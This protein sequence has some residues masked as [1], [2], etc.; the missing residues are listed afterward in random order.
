MSRT[1]NCVKA[2]LLLV[3]EFDQLR[4]A[5][6]SFADSTIFRVDQAHGV[7]SFKRYGFRLSLSLPPS[8]IVVLRLAPREFPT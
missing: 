3:V 6:S 8:S 2:T 7:R 5:T 4:L 1:N